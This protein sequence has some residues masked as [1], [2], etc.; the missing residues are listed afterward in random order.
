MTDVSAR[1]PAHL[2]TEIAELSRM[3]EAVDVLVEEIVRR[4][5][6][7]ADAYEADADCNY[8]VHAPEGV[9][10][11][12]WDYELAEAAGLNRLQTVVGAVGLRVGAALN[13]RPYPETCASYG[14]TGVGIT[15][16]VTP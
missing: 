1:V 3:A 8:G 9:N 14:L 6:R 5:G 4:Q 16:Q 12:D 2:L 7:L 11:S 13:G 10:P 15:E